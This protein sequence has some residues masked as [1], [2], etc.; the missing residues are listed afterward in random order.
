LTFLK[1]HQQLRLRATLLPPVSDSS[2]PSAITIYMK[3]IYLHPYAF[4]FSHI[5]E[6]L[7]VGTSVALTAGK[8]LQKRR[9]MA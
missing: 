4:L 7:S 1:I 6:W 3:Q 8:S 2:G 5:I 9:D